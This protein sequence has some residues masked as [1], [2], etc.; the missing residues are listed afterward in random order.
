MLFFKAIS[1]KNKIKKSYPIPLL[2]GWKY[3]A[4]LSVFGQGTSPSS[5]GGFLYF[6][7]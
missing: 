2:L 6:D 1:K 7:L 5:C 3:I 4:M